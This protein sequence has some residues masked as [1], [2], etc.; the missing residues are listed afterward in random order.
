VLAGGRSRRFGGLPKGLELVGQQ[1]IIDRVA[2]ALRAVTDDLLLAANDADAAAWLPGVRV[3]RDLRRD[4]GGLGGLESALAESRDVLIVAWDMPFVTADLLRRIVEEAR[5][6]DAIALVAPSDSPFGVE[7]FCG[8]YA[9]RAGEALARFLDSGQRAAHD[10]LVSLPGT[11][12]LNA[13]TPAL[14]P[15]SLLSVNTAE[16]LARAR[17]L[18]EHVE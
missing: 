10:F 17:A 8:F 7:P 2:T 1:R 14:T 15:H 3:A 12:V 4:A 6:T 18:A 11:R 5:V 9:A 13:N 16:D